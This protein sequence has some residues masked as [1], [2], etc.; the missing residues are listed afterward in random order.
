MAS[1]DR[2][3]IRAF[4]EANPDANTAD[5]RQ[6]QR[7]YPELATYIGRILDERTPA[8]P[9]DVETE[10]ATAP[11]SP[12]KGKKGDETPKE[13]EGFNPRVQAGQRSQ[14]QRAIGVRLDALSERVGKLPTPGGIGFLLVGILFFWFA[15]IPVN[16]ANTRLSLLWEMVQGN[17]S[18]PKKPTAG[19]TISNAISN[20]GGTW[21]N[22]L[23]PIVAPIIG[24]VIGSGSGPTNVPATT[25]VASGA[26][27]R[28]QAVRP[29]PPAAFGRRAMG[30]HSAPFNIS[31]V[32]YQA[33][34]VAE[35]AGEDTA[36]S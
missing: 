29:R 5:L 19:D 7:E 27:G 14:R 18:L 25:G 6:L 22:P 11:E 35:A 21:N 28:P 34:R 4:N 24:G 2:A 16:G 1:T 12:K 30:A 17:T 33:R 10:P 26:E 8:S 31:T 23:L 36:A 15:I 9:D 20:S 13:P 3:M 32:G